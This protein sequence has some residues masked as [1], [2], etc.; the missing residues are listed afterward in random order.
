M[1]CHAEPGL[2]FAGKAISTSARAEHRFDEVRNM[3]QDQHSSFLR[4]FVNYG[5]KFLI[6]LPEAGSKEIIIKDFFFFAKNRSLGV[7]VVKL[8]F[9]VTDPATK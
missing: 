9:L 8:I 4:I 6:A 1:F 5:P 7:D 2:I 3:N